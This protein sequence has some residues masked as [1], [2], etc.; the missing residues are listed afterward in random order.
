M[1][2][3]DVTRLRLAIVRLARRQRQ[4]SGIGLT[5]GLQSTL[6]SVDVHGPL[7][8]GDL[9]AI[10]QVAP[11]TMTRMVNRLEE[12]GLVTRTTDPED[13]RCVRVAMTEEGRAQL[14]ESR[15]RRDAWLAERLADLDPADRDALARAVEPLER[16]LARSRDDEPA[17]AVAT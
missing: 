10:E 4:Q 3:P 15:R 16:L 14:A 17:G 13:R 1:S 12:D 11:P 2:E 8:L 9:A 5:L 7:G 6:A